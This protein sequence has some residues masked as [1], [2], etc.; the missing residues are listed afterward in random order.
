MKSVLQH[1]RSHLSGT[2]AQLTHTHKCIHVRIHVCIAAR[3]YVI[4]ISHKQQWMLE[5]RLTCAT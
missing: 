1:R 4:K 5:C 2:T 3:V